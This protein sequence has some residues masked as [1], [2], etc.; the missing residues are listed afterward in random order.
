MAATAAASSVLGEH[1][2]VYG[3]A[4]AGDSDA[5]DGSQ[6]GYCKQPGF[7]LLRVRVIR[8]VLLGPRDA[9]CASA[10]LWLMAAQLVLHGGCWESQHC[11]CS[12]ST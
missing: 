5:G 12:N 8:D 6:T 1:G 3:D 4:D 7:S 10:A 11:S 9:V 2:L